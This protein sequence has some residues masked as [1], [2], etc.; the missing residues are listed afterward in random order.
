MKW[1]VLRE[2]KGKKTAFERTTRGQVTAYVTCWRRMPR[3]LVARVCGRFY[4]RKVVNVGV[5]GCVRD[6]EAVVQRDA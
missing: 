3:K 4:A 6:Y 1:S 2:F 5:C